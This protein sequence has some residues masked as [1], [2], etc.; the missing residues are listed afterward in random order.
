M[1]CHARILR[2]SETL[3]TLNNLM[4]GAAGFEPTTPT[5]PAW[6]ATRLRYAPNGHTI[7]E[8]LFD[9]TF[10]FQSDIFCATGYTSPI[11]T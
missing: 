3:V 1:F 8:N 11:R 7:A 4:V 5:P 2:F 6:C 9:A 10:V